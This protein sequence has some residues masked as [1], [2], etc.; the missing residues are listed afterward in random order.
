M[1][2]LWPYGLS[3]IGS[4]TFE[5]AAYVARYITKKVTGDNSFEHYDG[6]QPEFITMSRRPGIGR[7]WFDRFSSDVYPADSCFIR[8]TLTGTLKA[9]PPKYYDY[10]FDL[11]DSDAFERIKLKRVKMAKLSV[12]NTLDRLAVREQ[13]QLKKADKLLRTLEK[14]MM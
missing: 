4:V 12:H 13:V 9:K 2:E 8:N 1:E 6:R 5:S 11:Q 7:E 3:E 10:L 14:S